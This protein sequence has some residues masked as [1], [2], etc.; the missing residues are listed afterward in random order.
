MCACALLWARAC[1]CFY[2]SIEGKWRLWWNTKIKMCKFYLLCFPPH[3]T[4]I[5]VE[6]GLSNVSH[7]PQSETQ[8]PFQC[9]FVYWRPHIIRQVYYIKSTDAIKLTKW[10]ILVFCFYVIWS[11][12]N[13]L[14]IIYC[15]K[16]SNTSIGLYLCIEILYYKSCTHNFTNGTEE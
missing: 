13:D 1:V 7:G 14:Q 16:S 11:G 8:T 12:G 9:A 3:C 4:G 2:R 15:S 10:I 6:Q 5:Q